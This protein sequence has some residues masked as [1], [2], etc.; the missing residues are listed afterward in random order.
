MPSVARALT[1]AS[2]L[3]A[4]LAAA[5]PAAHATSFT[6]AFTPI[7]LD[8][9]PG[10]VVTTRV[11]LTL[12]PGPRPVHFRAHTEDWWRTADGLKTFYR[13][14]GTLRRSCAPWITLDPAEQEVAPGGKLAVR[15]T[16]AVPADIPP[17]GYWCAVTLNELPDPLDVARATGINFAASFSTGVYVFI[18]PLERDAVITDLRVSGDAVQVALRGT[19]NTP[20][21]VDGK[22]ELRRPGSDAIVATVTLDR[23]VLLPEPIASTVLHGE[24]PDA[25]ALPSGEYVLRGI[26]DVG[27]DHFLGAEKTVQVTRASA[28]DRK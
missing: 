5:A 18:A 6:A 25:A 19:G 28:T 10:D 27:L 16:I 9:R 17:G 8:A 26:V 3:A 24:L 1:V 11:A 22:V 12:G 4:A 20:L 23:N 15:L 7:R 21:R 13:P 2:A 14:A